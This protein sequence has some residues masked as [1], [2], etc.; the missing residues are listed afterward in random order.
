M[1]AYFYLNKELLKNYKNVLFRTLFLEKFLTGNKQTVRKTICINTRTVPLG[2]SP[3]RDSNI[4]PCF[5]PT[6]LQLKIIPRAFGLTEGYLGLFFTH[7]PPS[8]YA[9][10]MKS[11]L[12][13]LCRAIT[14]FLTF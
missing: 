7:R 10:W 8:P 2:L 5:R 14:V 6:R 1:V 13:I 3:T 4:F 9:L 11:S 12:C